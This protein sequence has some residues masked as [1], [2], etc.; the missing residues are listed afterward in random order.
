MTRGESHATAPRSTLHYFLL[1]LLGLFGV[2]ISMPIFYH[3]QS[4]TEWID[5][6]INLVIFI[7][8]SLVAV[9]SGLLAT[10]SAVFSC[11]PDE[12]GRFAAFAHTIFKGFG[13]S[14]RWGADGAARSPLGFLRARSI[15]R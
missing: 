12:K 8:C 3:P 5:L 15:R 7:P 4:T 2:Y 14:E 1:V 6:A 13:L 10:F 11:R 9:V